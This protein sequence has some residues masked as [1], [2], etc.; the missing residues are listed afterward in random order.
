MNEPI[1]QLP[2]R[3]K[4]IA[5]V[6]MPGT[7]KSTVG[8]LL[9]KSLIGMTFVDTD[10]LYEEIVGETIKETFAREGEEVF[11]KRETEVLET[12]VKAKKQVIGTGGGIVL[13]EANRKLLKYNCFVVQLTAEPETV[14]SRTRVS[15]RRPLLQDATPRSIA[16]IYKVRKPLYDEVARMTISTDYKHPRFITREILARICDA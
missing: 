10:I 3:G 14:Y 7:F 15:G 1:R 2:Y 12:A 8:K 5:L 9:A 6:G 13:T 4:N 11:R 16:E